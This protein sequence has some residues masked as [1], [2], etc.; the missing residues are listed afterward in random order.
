MVT[1]E[2]DRA[3][4]A[5]DRPSTESGLAQ[6]PMQWSLVLQTLNTMQ[7]NFGTL[8]EAVSTIKHQ[9]DDQGKKIGRLQLIIAAAGGAVA[10]AALVGGFL[11]DK[12]LGNIIRLL[13]VQ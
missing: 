4:P 11:V 9:L 7:R 10:V 1:P 2:T 12:G 8:H 6:E 5:P 13:G 3:T